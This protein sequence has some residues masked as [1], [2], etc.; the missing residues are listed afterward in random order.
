MLRPV[1]GRMP[2]CPG[3]AVQSVLADEG[4]AAW[5]TPSVPFSAAGT[6]SGTWLAEIVTFK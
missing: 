5:I 6:G 4:R 3:Q 2:A 1:A